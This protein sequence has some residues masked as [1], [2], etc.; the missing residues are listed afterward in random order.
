[1]IIWRDT[2]LL[3]DLMKCCIFAVPAV[4]MYITVRSVSKLFQTGI[5]QLIIEIIV[6][7]IVYIV[8]GVCFLFIINKKETLAMIRAALKRHKK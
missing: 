4:F 6:G 7:G 3:I 5:S 2:Q 1:M 8:V